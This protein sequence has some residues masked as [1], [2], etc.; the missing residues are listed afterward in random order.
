MFKTSKFGKIKDFFDSTF[1]MFMIP[2]LL[3]LLM[4]G[5]LVFLARKDN[6]ENGSLRI[7]TDKETGCQ[8]IGTAWSL[9]GTA[10][11]PR[12]DAQGKPMCGLPADIE[13]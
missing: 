10:L 13:G 3:A 4:V 2:S 7:H 8:Y 12:L 11:T 9:G 5:A 1:F 6:G